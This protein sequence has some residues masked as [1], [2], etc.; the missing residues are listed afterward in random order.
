MFYYEKRTPEKLAGLELDECLAHGWFRMHQTIFTQSHEY[1]IN[2]DKF[3]DLHWL[4]FSVDE[5]RRHG[6]HKKMNKRNRN[7]TCIIEHEPEISAEMAVLYQR[8]FQWVR[9]D[10]PK[11]I[12]D[13]LFQCSNDSVFNT[14]LIKIYDQNRLIAAGFFD[15]GVNAAASILHF[16]DPGYAD[17]SPGKYLMLQT[18]EYM[19]SNSLQWYY[20][21][22]LIAGNSIMNY[23]L[24]LGEECAQYYDFKTDSWFPYHQEILH[25][26]S[27]TQETTDKWCGIYFKIT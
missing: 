19:K 6:S 26:K 3:I 13:V 18:V 11:T 9:H 24:F 16:Y 12:E 1:D 2:S 23:K 17:Y 22:Y 20:P 5:I 14:K 21:G 4:R 8:Y 15:T 27:Y 25:S 7:F 10:I